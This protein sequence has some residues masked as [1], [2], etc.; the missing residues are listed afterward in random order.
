M[1]ENT[2]QVV[3]ATDGLLSFVFF[4]YDDIEWGFANIGFSAG[5]RVRFLM[6]PGALTFQSRN[7]ETTSNVNITGLYIY[8][9]D[10]RTV[11]GPSGEM[12]TCTGISNIL[13]LLIQ[14]PLHCSYCIHKN[15]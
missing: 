2:F 3:L 4:V 13:R 12:L 6:V 1:Q 15:I 9:V 10:L 11:L 8:R 5:D 14:H 7:I